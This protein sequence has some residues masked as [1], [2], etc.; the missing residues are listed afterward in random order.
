[1]SSSGYRVPAGRHRA[2]TVERRSR[3]VATVDRA[4]SVE[5]ARDLIAA[6][7]AEMPDA[8]HHVYAFVVGSGLS[9]TSG[10]SDD[11]EPSG[12][13]GRPVLA[14][15]QGSGLGD[16]CLVVSRYYGGTKLGTG[17][18]VRAYARAARLVLAAVPT[19]LH[20][21]RSTAALVL[22]Y[23]HYDAALRLLEAHRATLCRSD[24]EATVRLEVDL[25]ASEWEALDAALSELTAGRATLLRLPPPD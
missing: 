23:S 19:T 12:T 18:L 8:T 16:V 11:G 5:A 3:F 4:A 9:V 14:V 21:E 2:E 22:A 10:L 25:P 17:G 6:V 7:R 15:L 24:F 20:E 13:A 1:M